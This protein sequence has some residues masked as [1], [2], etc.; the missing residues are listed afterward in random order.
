MLEQTALEASEF[1]EGLVR[2][3]DRLYQLLWQSGTILSYSIPG[4]KKVAWCVC[5]MQHPVHL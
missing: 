5:S 2:L 1:G 4:L 3:G